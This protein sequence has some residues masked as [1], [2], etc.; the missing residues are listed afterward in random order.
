MMY[1]P[2]TSLLM[3]PRTTRLCC[4]PWSQSCGCVVSSFPPRTAILGMATHPTL[5]WELMSFSQ[6]RCFPH[7]VNVAVQAILKMI[8]DISLSKDGAVCHEVPST[9][10]HTFV[11]V[12]GHNP[13]ACGHAVVRAC[14]SSGQCREHLSQLIIEGNIKQTFG[15]SDEPVEVPNLALLC[16][17]DTRWDS[18][19]LMICHLRVLRPVHVCHSMESAHPD[20]S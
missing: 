2:A 19:Y 3:V 17:V 18:V 11:E 7:L 1:R 4:E 8:T 15:P 14:H 9:Q 6:Y 16:D 13:I 12:L 20:C 10:G 5:I